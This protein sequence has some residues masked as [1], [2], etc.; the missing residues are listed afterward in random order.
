M[1]EEEGCSSPPGLAPK[2]SYITSRILFYSYSQLDAK[3]QDKIMAPKGMM[4]PQMEGARVLKSHIKHLPQCVYEQEMSLYCAKASE[5]WKLFLKHFGEPT[6]K[7][8]LSDPNCP[9]C[10]QVSGQSAEG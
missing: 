2:C 1:E 6:K 9:H 10:T 3:F 7:H 4:K 8:W 5:L